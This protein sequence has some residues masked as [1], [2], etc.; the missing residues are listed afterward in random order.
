MPTDEKPKPN[1]TRDAGAAGTPRPIPAAPPGVRDAGAAGGAG[2]TPTKNKRPGLGNPIGIS[3]Y[4]AW[5]SL[6]GQQVLGSLA[7]QQ[8][9]DRIDELKALAWTYRNASDD[10]L[11][12]ALIQ[13][14]FVST[15]DPDSPGGGTR[16]GG[17]G[18]GASKA[19][20]YAAAR[21]ALVN[22]S[23]SLGIEFDD[24]AL[25]AL[26]QT[27]VEGNWTNAQV[28]DY[29]L[30]AQATKPGLI[31]AGID[32][33][34]A[35]GAQQ[36]LKISDATAREYAARIESGEQTM[37]GVKSAFQAQA[38]TQFGWAA[39]LISQGVSVR[40]ILLPARDKIAALLEISP[41][42]VDLMDDRYLNMVQTTD[43][44]GQVRAATLG[45]V[46][47]RARKDDRYR[48]T[49]G[50]RR[51]TANVGVTLAR[52]FSGANG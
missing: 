21:A 11:I 16:G 6:N 13:N 1:P 5:W 25:D 49:E 15:D 12:D 44:K 17:G 7:A 48:Q 2:T 41:D 26:A 46:A 51:D 50:A 45:E 4:D 47:Q 8:H 20:Q 42:S 24:G 38:Q 10:D 30:G 28:D 35:L 33:I 27:V 3:E 32:Q 43:E 31:T 19:Q 23:R 18:G 40:D 29:I 52:M 39:N 36:M 14:G 22:R 37:E 9:P 34:K